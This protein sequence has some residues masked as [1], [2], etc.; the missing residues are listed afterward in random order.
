MPSDRERINQLEVLIARTSEPIPMQNTPNL[1]AL[2]LKL[3]NVTL[4]ME[5]SWFSDQPP[6]RNQNLKA[7]LESITIDADAKRIVCAKFALDSP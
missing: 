1:A 4:G 7:L 5:S 2:A 3:T 6:A